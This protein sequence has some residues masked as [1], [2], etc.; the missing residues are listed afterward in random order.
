MA[1]IKGGLLFHVEGSA[2]EEK[3]RSVILLFC[4]FIRT[5][6]GEISGRGKNRQV[7]FPLK[8]QLI[9]TITKKRMQTLNVRGDLTIMNDNGIVVRMWM[10]CGKEKNY[11]FFGANNPEEKTAKRRSIFSSNF[12]AR[13]KEDSLR[14]DAKLKIR[15]MSYEGE[16]NSPEVG[17]L[18]GLL[19]L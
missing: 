18:A 6:G 17:R 8:G 1:K 11:H 15:L 7:R 9:S 5:R 12:S 10:P 2:Q 19:A 14:G 3:G 16:N 13:S 4:G